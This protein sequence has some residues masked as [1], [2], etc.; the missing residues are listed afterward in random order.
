MNRST[1]FM[2]SLVGCKLV[3]QRSCSLAERRAA[4][5]TPAAAARVILGIESSCD[6]TAVGIVTSDG[7]V[8]GEAI[9]GQAEVHAPW[10]GVVPSL[11]QEAHRAA[12]DR[13]VSQALAQ[14]QL[15]LHDMDAIAVTVGPGLSLCLDVGVRKARALSRAAGLPLIPVH[16]MEAHALVARMAATPQQLPF[17]FLCLLVSGG[18][19]LLVLVRGVGDYLQLGTTVDDAIGELPPS[20]QR[21]PGSAGTM[22]AGRDQL[23]LYTVWLLTLTC[24]GWAGCLE[25]YGITRG[26]RACSSHLSSLVS[27]PAGEAYD[28]VARMLGLELRPHG[29]AALEALAKAGKLTACS[30]RPPRGG[31]LQAR[32][33]HPALSAPTRQL[34]G[35]GAGGSHG[36]G[37][38]LHG[39]LASPVSRLCVLQVTQS[40]F[41][42][43]CQWFASPTATSRML[44]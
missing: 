7:R 31:P 22:R 27:S 32:A 11:A 8:L 26:R 9:A 15:Q 23:R 2:K 37:C 20:H 19:N 36:R 13:V 42:L 41:S 4:L 16:H 12:I 17:P 34:L 24:K 40:A 30:A 5:T 38:A 21:G 35:P 28:K 1:R 25:W 6:D 39:C 10:G 18:H 29:G 43:Q 44:A 3:R 33:H 14:A